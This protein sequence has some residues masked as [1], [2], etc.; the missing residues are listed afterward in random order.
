M[1]R[2]I[3]KAAGE[4]ASREPAAA[5]L[6]RPRPP[7]P[8]VLLAL[9]VAVFSSTG[10][11]EASWSASS[12]RL[13]KPWRAVTALRWLVKAA[14]SDLAGGDRAAP[15]DTPR[16]AVSEVDAAWLGVLRM[17]GERLLT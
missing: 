10:V 3:P 17:P 2:G 7:P 9:D 8:A 16:E 11:E 4:E 13:R 15:R 12:A 6:E 5:A 14:R 1:R